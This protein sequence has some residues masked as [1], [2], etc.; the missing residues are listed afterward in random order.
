MTYMGVEF[1]IENG[2]IIYPFSGTHLII[3]ISL[4]QSANALIKSYI[5]K[6]NRGTLEL[7]PKTTFPHNNLVLKHFEEIV[8][9]VNKKF[10]LEYSW[11]RVLETDLLRKISEDI[12]EAINNV[13]PK[14]Q[15]LSSKTYPGVF[16]QVR[17]IL[18]P[19][20]QALI[21]YRRNPNDRYII[22][23]AMSMDKWGNIPEVP[24][25]MKS[26]LA[27]YRSKEVG[28]RG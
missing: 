17:D 6:L 12:R 3:P 25:Y 8:Y 10:T 26:A 19:H 22:V 7:A 13:L 11:I 28:Q 18:A 15:Q 1:K 5:D 2:N 20:Y 23:P 21:K 24:N 27:E 9:D 4:G 14:L 16:T